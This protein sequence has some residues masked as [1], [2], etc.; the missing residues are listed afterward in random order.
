MNYRY[1][2]QERIE[3]CAAHLAL[4]KLPKAILFRDDIVRSPSGK[5]DYRWAKDPVTSERDARR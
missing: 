2:E 3:A 4:Y 1:V 5:A